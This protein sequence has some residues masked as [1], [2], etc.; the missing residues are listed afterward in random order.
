MNICVTGRQLEVTDAIRAQVQRRADKLPHFWDRVHDLDAILE[1]RGSHTYRAELV[2]RADG[3][4]PF[5]A[6][7]KHDDLYAAIDEAATKLE[8]QV[9]N[10]HAKLV[11]HK[12]A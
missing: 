6:T 7:V 4:D 10:H 9:R 8:R 2:A 1:K 11:D 12:H 3:T 5:I